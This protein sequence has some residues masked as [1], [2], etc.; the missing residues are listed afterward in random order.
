MVHPSAGTV[1]GNEKNVSRLADL[2][3]QLQ[4]MSVNT[5]TSYT[6]SVCM[7]WN[8][9]RKSNSTGERVAR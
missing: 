9:E 5:R 2:L 6:H 1:P 3:E 8:G 4:E 7:K